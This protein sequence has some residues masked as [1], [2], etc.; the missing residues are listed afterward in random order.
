MWAVEG[1]GQPTAGMVQVLEAQEKE[2]AQLERD[3]DAWIT[4]DVAAV[5]QKAAA[6]G[7]QFIVIK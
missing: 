1:E 4:T 2:L 7:V 6:A 3:T 5:N